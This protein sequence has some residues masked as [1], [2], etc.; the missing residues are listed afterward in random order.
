MAREKKKIK[1]LAKYLLVS[2][3]TAKQL[4]QNG[5]YIVL[6]DKEAN[7]TAR[8]VITQNLYNF[9]ADFILDHST[10]LK[11]LFTVEEFNELKRTHNQQFIN[12]VIER[13]LD[14]LEDFIYDA[15][16]YNGRAHF[17]SFVGGSEIKLNNLYIYQLS[18]NEIKN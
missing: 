4:I 8:K 7:A 3:K 12:V 5:D 9:D 13:S 2:K 18:Y 16:N 17:I 15:L 6:T 10:F 1:T 14:A 11:E